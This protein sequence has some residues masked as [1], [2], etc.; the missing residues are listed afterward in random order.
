[1]EEN[2]TT[3]GSDEKDILEILGLFE[4]ELDERLEEE[5]SE[6]QKVKYYEQFKINEINF[7]NIFITTEKDVEGK[8]TYHVYCGDSS[9]EIL[10][11][12]LEGKVEINNPELAKYL[13][14][15][16]FEKV[17][18][19]NEKEP[20]KLKGISKKATPEEMEKTLT[21]EKT[22]DE[23][24]E[25][26]DEET[27]EIEEDL[28]EQG[29]DLRI[30][31]YRKVKDSKVSERMP[32]VFQDGTENGIAFSNKLNRFVIISKIDG[33]YCLNE[34]AE[35]ARMTWKTITSISP[36]GEKV[37]RKV[38][39][40]LI[41]ISN[42]DQK[43]IAISIDQ[44]GDVDIETVDVLPCQQRIAR[45][46][47][48]EGEGLESQESKNVTDIFEQEGE[49]ITSH[50]IAHK[51]EE[52]E[53]QFNVVISN[54]EELRNLDIEAIMEAEAQRA[55]VSKES[56]KEYVRNADGKTLEEKIEDA[57]EQIEQEYRGVQ[58]PR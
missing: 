23:E 40:A 11:I 51:K 29:E 18:E 43:E 24:K 16:D 52:I 58:R 13:G 32:E 2:K 38:P 48:E 57:H 42:N 7:K 6:V 12:N 1:M 37:E 19:E 25:N 56:F 31:K 53:R 14:E 49:V 35:P 55:K 3:F 45:A 4:Q 34:N 30:S 41:Q 54:I 20:G 44:Y 47:R 36:D 46:V 26:Q 28:Q 8:V 10:S 9:N 27:Q 50:E 21:G 22:T 5:K 17:I 33:H 39:H 15:V